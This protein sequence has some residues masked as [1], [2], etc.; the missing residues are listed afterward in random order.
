[1]PRLGVAQTP[2]FYTPANELIETTCLTTHN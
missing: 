2:E 1:M